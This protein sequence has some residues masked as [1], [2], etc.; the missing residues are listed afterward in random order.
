MATLTYDNKSTTALTNDTRSSSGTLTNDSK[1][2][3]EI[4]WGSM[5]SMWQDE[6]R[7]W[8]EVDSLITLDVKN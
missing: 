3:G 6:L 2:S 8:G 5:L 4:T 1:S 7:T